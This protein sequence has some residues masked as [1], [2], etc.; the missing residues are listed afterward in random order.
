MI[1]STRYWPGELPAP[2]LV[3]VLSCL[4]ATL[5]FVSAGLLRILAVRYLPLKKPSRRLATFGLLSILLLGPCAA[6]LLWRNHSLRALKRLLQ[7]RTLELRAFQASHPELDEDEV[8]R[9]FYRTGPGPWT[10]RFDERHTYVDVYPTRS[11]DGV[12]F[13]VNFGGRGADISV[14]DPD[15]MIVM[16]SY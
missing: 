12:Y 5:F 14:F 11:N 16:N 1:D 9:H 2:E 7:D 4:F 13:A 10:F 3:G 8:V 15:T 6:G